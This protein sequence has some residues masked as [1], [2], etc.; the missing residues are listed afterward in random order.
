[1]SH[2]PLYQTNLPLWACSDPFTS[3]SSRDLFIRS[4][5]TYFALSVT[6]S[7]DGLE[8]YWLG[9]CVNHSWDLGNWGSMPATLLQF[10]ST[11]GLLFSMMLPKNSHNNFSLCSQVS[12]Y[13][14]PKTDPINSCFWWNKIPKRFFI[15]VSKVSSMFKL[16]F[17]VILWIDISP[18]H[19][20]KLVAPHTY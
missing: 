6:C 5:W 8:Q 12:I 10:N 18:K 4:T 19:S 14:I 15:I 3:F 2:L 11:N 7:W 1:M 20:F 13:E 17:Q 16:Y 9:I